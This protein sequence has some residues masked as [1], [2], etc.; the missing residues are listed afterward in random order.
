MCHDRVFTRFL[1]VCPESQE[2]PKLTGFY[3]VNHDRL[4]SGYGK[5]KCENARSEI[6]YAGI[7]H[8]TRLCMIA[9]E[10]RL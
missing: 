7:A 9:K 4:Y 10:A 1:R 3:V 8:Y 5:E 6:E 2:F